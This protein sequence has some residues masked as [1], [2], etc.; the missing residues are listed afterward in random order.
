MT[1]TFKTGNSLRGTIKR[2]AKIGSTKHFGTFCELEWS[3]DLIGE[4]GVMHLTDRVVKVHMGKGGLYYK[5][6]LNWFIPETEQ[7]IIV[8]P[9]P[10]VVQVVDN[11]QAEA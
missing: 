11:Q 7:T 2:W 10:S 8:K 5:K 4:P 1:T 3:K 6:G 9:R